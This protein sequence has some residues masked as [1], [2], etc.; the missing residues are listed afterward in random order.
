M[1]RDE[2]ARRAGLEPSG[3]TFSTYLSRLAGN[4]LVVKAGETVRAA[5]ALFRRVIDEPKG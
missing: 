3:G 5:D 2:L 1:T 4:E